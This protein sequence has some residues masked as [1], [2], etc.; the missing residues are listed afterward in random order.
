MSDEVAIIRDDLL[1]FQSPVDAQNI[2]NL[3]VTDETDEKTHSKR[4]GIKL[5][6]KRAQKT[7]EIIEDAL[8]LSPREIEQL[9]KQIG[10][11]HGELGHVLEMSDEVAII[12]DDLLQ[13]PSPVDA[14]NSK[15]LQ[16]TDETDEKTHSK[17]Q[18]V[19]LLPEAMTEID[20]AIHDEM[21][22]SPIEIERLS[23]KVGSK[24][25]SLGCFAGMLEEVENVRD[26]NRRFPDLVQKA[27][28]IL[29]IINNRSNFSRKEL[30]RHLKE[31]GLGKLANDL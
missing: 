15:N 29:T 22:L 27:A 20:D 21:R 6:R 5:L 28:E 26:D 3:K 1:Q 17:I 16:I 25:S 14:Q 12:R 18:G 7:D 11:D 19:K 9:S 13:F 10:Q 4:R 8:K 31:I 2:K 23:P 24:Y 30:S